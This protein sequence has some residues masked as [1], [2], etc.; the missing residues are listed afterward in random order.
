MQIKESLHWL[1]KISKGYRLRILSNSIVGILY[2]IVSLLFVWFSKTLIDIATGQSSA[3]LITFIILIILCIIAQLLFSFIDSRI[4]VKTEIELRSKLRYTLFAR[5]MESRWMGREILHTG[6]IVNRL[7]SDVL[8]VTDILTRVIPSVI[9]TITQFLGAFIFLCKLDFRLASILIFIMPFALLLSK[10]YMFTMRKLTKNI[11]ATDSQVQSHL[12][13]HLQHRTLISTLENTSYVTNTLASLQNNLQQQVVHRMNFSLFSRTMVQAGFAIG[14]AIAFLWGVMGLRDGA[15]TFGMMTAFLQLVAQIQRPMIELSRQ[16]PTFINA[17]TS[18]DRLT[19]LY[20]LPLEE[21]GES[22]KLSGQIGIRLQGL[23]FA[24][25][26]SDKNIIDDF[27]YDFTPGS[28]TAIVGETGIGKSTLIRIML[29]LL[30]PQRGDVSLYNADTIVKASPL[31]R[32]NLVYIPQGNTLISGSIRD[33]LLL[34]NP[35]ATDEELK[36]V[37][38]SA[39]ADFV[40]SLPDGLDTICGELGTGLS[41]GQAQRIAIARGLLRPGGIILLD[42]PTSSLDSETELLLLERLSKQIKN[43]TLILITHRSTIAQL[44]TNIIQMKNK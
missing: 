6:D 41:D 24:Y 31:T 23:T 37:L 2:V 4:E 5:L 27:T 17:I 44:C 20:D 34:G 21:K 22:I 29:A 32:C 11:R 13:E 26:G 36:E 7:E 25:P 10:R 15:V 35:K 19:E 40:Y 1:W 30:L 8:T 43:K 3:N 9:V 33:N 12:Q 28:F 38:H 39:V 14:Y 16:I 18:C 42:E